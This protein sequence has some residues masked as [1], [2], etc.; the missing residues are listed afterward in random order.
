M[1][2]LL[3]YLWAVWAQRSQRAQGSQRV[4]RP[5]GPNGPKWTKSPKGPK[6]PKEPKGPKRPS[7]PNGPKGPKGP[8]DPRGCCP[9][10]GS[11]CIQDCT[12]KVIFLVN[13]VEQITEILKVINH[14]IINQFRSI[15]TSPRFK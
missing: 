12:A 1:Q 15:T 8:K 11:R 14:V 6:G 9:L 10:D 13:F 7:G 3:I 2:P 4:P 5:S